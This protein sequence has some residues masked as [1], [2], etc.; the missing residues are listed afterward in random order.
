MKK[1]ELVIACP[2]K[3]SREDQM[4]LAEGSKQTGGHTASHNGLI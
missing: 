3:R 4:K 2:E 1:E